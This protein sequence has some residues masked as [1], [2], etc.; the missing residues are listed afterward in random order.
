MRTLDEYAAEIRPH[1][2]ES[3]FLRTDRGK[4]L[5][6]T[7]APARQKDFELRLDGYEISAKGGLMHISP[8]LNELKCEARAL[9]I[10]Y[11]KA[12]GYEKEKALR[13][14]LA[15]CLRAKSTSEAKYLETQLSEIPN[16][17]Q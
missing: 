6:V 5:F 1:L 3:A 10:K 11:L 15:L 17:T 13:Q 16:D 9:Y 4:A 14:C 2:P 8:A 12:R 7:D